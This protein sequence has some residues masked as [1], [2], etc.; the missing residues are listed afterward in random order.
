VRVN[1]ILVNSVAVE[2]QEVL[3]TNE[4]VFVALGTQHAKP[5]RR[6]VT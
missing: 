6:I 4:C 2:K 3:H 1:Y 5:M